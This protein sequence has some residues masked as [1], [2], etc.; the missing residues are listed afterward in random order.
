M[1]SLNMLGFFVLIIRLFI[2]G[3][4]IDSERVEV[5][6]GERFDLFDENPELKNVSRVSMF[7]CENG[8]L[9]FRYCSPDEKKNGCKSFGADKVLLQTQ[10]MTLSIRNASSSDEGCYTLE[11]IGN[12]IYKK[13]LTVVV[14]ESPLSTISPESPHL[15]SPTP[16]DGD[17]VKTAAAAIL[18]GMF[19]LVISIICYRYKKKKSQKKSAEALVEECALNQGVVADEGLVSCNMSVCVFSDSLKMED[20]TLRPQRKKLSVEDLNHNSIKENKEK[21]TCAQGL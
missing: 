12:I 5:T 3:A 10:N 9:V 21:P 1:S 2:A 11:V 4:A 17:S 13:K 15:T 19:I 8:P 7:I 16:N 6:M 14:N 18:I 20:E